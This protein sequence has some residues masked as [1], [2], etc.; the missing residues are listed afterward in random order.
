MSDLDDLEEVE[1]LY[2]REG[3][4]NANRMRAGAKF[5]K[6]VMAGRMHSIR[7]RQLSSDAHRKKKPITLAGS[8]S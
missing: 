3:G 7:A 2:Q 8:K 1:A 4:H 6:H 5:A